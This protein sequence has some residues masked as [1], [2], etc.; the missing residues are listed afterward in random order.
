MNEVDAILVGSMLGD[1]SLTP[2]SLR[3]Q[4][5]QLHLGY[6]KRYWSYL[7][8]LHAKLRPL[9]VYAIQPKRGFEQFHLYSKPSS[10]L[11]RLRNQFYPQG[12]KLIPSD[13]AQMLIRPISLAVW[14]MDDGSLDFRE[15]Y[16]ANASI[17]TYN[18][19]EDDCHRLSGVLQDNFGLE[20]KVHRSTM[21]GKVY[22]RIYFPSKSM[23][24]FMRLIEPY[25]QPCFSYKTLMR[26][27]SSRGNTEGANVIRNHWA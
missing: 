13:I 15:G 19:S 25:M 10:E 3:K 23:D 22:F 6:S 11:G 12:I 2:L 9:G 20:A 18:F 5:S 4:E 7:V 24:L 16:H 14:Y 1:G 27:A 17:A 26:V 21:R 8:W